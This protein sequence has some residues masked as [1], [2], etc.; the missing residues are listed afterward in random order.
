MLRPKIQ[1]V[2]PK[3]PN[4]SVQKY[5]A[6]KSKK[7]TTQQSETNVKLEIW[8]NVRPMKTKNPN[9]LRPQITKE[10]FNYDKEEKKIPKTMDLK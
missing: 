6:S 4:L 2:R 7:S 10:T 9:N 5:Y 3:N 8:K 1:Q